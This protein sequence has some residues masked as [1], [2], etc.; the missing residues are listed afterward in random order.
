MV[1]YTNSLCMS[2][3]N[4]RFESQS[5]S[6]LK[7]NGHAGI[8]NKFRYTRLQRAVSS[9]TVPSGAAFC[10]SFSANNPNFHAV[11]DVY[12]ILL[13]RISTLALT[14]SLVQ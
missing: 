11:K 8:Y 7:I 14:R 5:H 10:F 9:K 2:K 13:Y 3:L 4:L 6:F 1:F 12:S